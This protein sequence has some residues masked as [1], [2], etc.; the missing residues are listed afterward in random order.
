VGVLDVLEGIEGGV[1]SVLQP[2]VELLSL[3]PVNCH[4]VELVKD[5]GLENGV[6][7]DGDRHVLSLLLPLGGLLS[8]VLLVS[9]HVKLVG[10]LG[11]ESGVVG[12]GGQRVLS[13]VPRLGVLLNSV[14]LVNL[15]VNLVLDK[16]YSG[17]DYWRILGVL[18]RLVSQQ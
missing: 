14:L 11:F 17:D 18:P 13:V 8:S 15:H 6:T 3:V 9:L 10:G 7:G 1:N 16:V 2:H 5:P 4:L 12:D